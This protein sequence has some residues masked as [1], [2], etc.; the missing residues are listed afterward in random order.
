MMSPTLENLSIFS[1]LLDE[2]ESICI[3]LLLDINALLDILVKDGYMDDVTV[4]ALSKRSMDICPSDDVFDNYMN[5]SA[6]IDI[7][8]AMQMHL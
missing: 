3:K 7:E 2:S 1:V 8:D 5:G 6:Y 4:N